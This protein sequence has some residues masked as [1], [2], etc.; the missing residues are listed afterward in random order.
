MFW[1]SMELFWEEEDGWMGGSVEGSLLVLLDEGLE[2]GGVGTDKLVD[3]LAVAVE[4]EGGHRAHVALLDDRLVHVVHVDRAEG[5]IGVLLRELGE[6][7]RNH[8]ARAAPLG[9]KVHHSQ[10]V[11]AGLHEVVPLCAG[12]HD[13]GVAHCAVCVCWDVRSVWFRRKR[14]QSVGRKKKRIEKKTDVS[15]FL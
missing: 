5:D 3:E 8:A 15:A 13:L 12:S 10:L 11:P 6:R 1:S 4:L 2:L 9:R 7:R 14:K